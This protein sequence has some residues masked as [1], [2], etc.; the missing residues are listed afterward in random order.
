MPAP[1]DDTDNGPPA[2]SEDRMSLRAI[3]RLSG[4]SHTAMRRRYERGDLPPP[5]GVRPGGWPFW[6][7]DDI[8]R[9][10]EQLPLD[11]CS[12]CGVKTKRLQWHVDQSHPEHGSRR[13]DA[14][15]PPAAGSTWMST[16]DVA[17]ELQVGILVVRGLITTGE[18]PARRDADGSYR[19]ERI[20]FETWLDQQ[21][22]LT[23]T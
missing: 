1:I 7:G 4:I 15:L 10:L 19:V 18:L 23:R 16:K 22:Q 12:L 20:L 21:Y 6:R 14:S 13:L 8:R 5:A 3:A 17:H 2:F 9:W 11:Q